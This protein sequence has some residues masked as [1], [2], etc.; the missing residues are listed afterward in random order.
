MRIA[1]VVAAIVGI[2]AVVCFMGCE[3]DTVYNIDGD[4]EIGTVQFN[5]G[6]GK[7]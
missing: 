6:G 5:Y 7:T 4:W 1:A 2:V 3:G